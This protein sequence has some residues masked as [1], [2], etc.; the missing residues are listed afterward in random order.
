MKIY[1]KRIKIFCLIP[2]FIWLFFSLQLFSQSVARSW[3]EQTLSAIRLDVPH[4]P[5]HAR[6]LFHVSVAMWDAWAAYDDA[7]GYIHNEKAVV[8][9]LNGDGIADDLVESRQKAI[10][11]AA[12]RVLKSRYR[13]SVGSDSTMQ[14]LL[15]LMKSLGYD[16]TEEDLEG[17][18]PSAVGNRIANSI[19]GFFWDDGSRESD[20]YVDN[21]YSPVNDALPLDE[22]LFTLLT[23]F[24]PTSTNNSSKNQN[25]FYNI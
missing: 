7:I 21:T 23:T 15:Q 3:N 10:S 1:L 24:N 2:C 20:N 12:Y 22:P 5:V 18:S 6:N 17:T 19:I 11:F 14:S 8:D 13:N 9:D 4:P 16:E 25:F